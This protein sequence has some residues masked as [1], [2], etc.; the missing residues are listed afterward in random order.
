[1]K[2]NLNSAVFLPENVIEVLRS[3]SQAGFF[4]QGLLIG[5]WVMPI[6]QEIFKIQYKLRT[7]DID[8]ALDIIP[9]KV[10]DYLDLEKIIT[11]LGYVVVT[12]YQTGLR[13]FSKEGFA[14]EFL[15]HR[16]GGRDV[17]KIEVK[18]LKVNALPL[19][20]INVLFL[21]PLIVDF[22]EYSIR[23]PSPETLFIHK[24]I[25]A[26]RRKKEVKK[27]NDLAQCKVLSTIVDSEKLSQ[28]SDSLNLSRKN[29]KLMIASCDAINFPPPMPILK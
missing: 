26:Q 16:K 10:S 11:D 14:I 13:K 7:F 19:P 9:P 1:M 12:D 22:G 8:F 27:E 2:V 20:F 29:R 24:L 25:I 17:P 23:I 3:L 18:H 6:Y 21:F 28:I 4:A 5:S 15:I